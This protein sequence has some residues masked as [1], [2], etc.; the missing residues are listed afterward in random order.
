MP[1]LKKKF[2]YAEDFA[3]ASLKD[4]FGAD[5][6]ANAQL[7]TANYFPNAVFINDRKGHFEASALPFEAQLTSF[8]DAV[9]VNANNDNLPD[10]L[11]MGN[12]YGNNIEMGRYDADYGTLLIN[13]GKGEFTCSPMNGLSV[14]GQ[15]RHIRKLKAGNKNALILACN[16][17][18]A[19][20]I[21]FND[22]H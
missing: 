22:G 9:V 15:V 20:I 13:K 6:L 5:Q 17:D 1:F 18:S 3:R 16:S 4:L 7:F 2:L 19:R 14:K 12:Y 8:R 21:Y 10:I 11:L